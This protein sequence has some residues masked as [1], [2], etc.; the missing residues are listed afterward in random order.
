[1]RAFEYIYFRVW[2]A[3]QSFL[4]EEYEPQWSAL[5]FMSLLIFVNYMDIVWTVERIFG[6]FPVVRVLTDSYAVVTVISVNIAI[7]Y[8]TVYR[9]PTRSRIYEMFSAE[10]REVKD[11][12]AVYFR[13]YLTIT[14]AWLVVLMV[15]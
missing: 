5:L 6:E 7:G 1:M 15:V 11:R 3:L 12:R 14:F 13:M 8:F 4:P 10:S 2:R 9:E